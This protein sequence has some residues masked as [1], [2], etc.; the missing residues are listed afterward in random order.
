VI[1]ERSK[2]SVLT[3]TVRG[4]TA[5]E[6]TTS[7]KLLELEGERNQEMSKSS[8]PIP[9]PAK[10]THDRGQKARENVHGG[11]DGEFKYSAWNGVGSWR[12]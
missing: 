4:N 12:R 6:I 1:L 7:R 11:W 8:L 3:E 2:F 5:E 9:S 10:W